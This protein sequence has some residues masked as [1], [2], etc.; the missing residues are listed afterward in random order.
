M[1]QT[2]PDQQRPGQQRRP[3]AQQQTRGAAVI[4]GQ[5][6][7]PCAQRHAELNGGHLKAPGTLRFIWHRVSHPVAPGDGHDAVRQAP[8]RQQDDCPEG[9]VADKQQ[10]QS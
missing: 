10:A 7:Q 4:E 6:T 9:D 3:T 1:I 2:L 5:S 8:Q